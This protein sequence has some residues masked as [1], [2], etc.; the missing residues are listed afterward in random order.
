MNID[1]IDLKILNFLQNDARLSNQELADLVNLS[2]SACHRRVKL[3]ERNGIIEKYQARLNYEKLGI[4]IE[5]IVEIKLIQLTETDHNFFLKQIEDFEEV[6]NAYVITGESNYVLHVATKDLNA[7]SQF[8]INK[9]NKIKGIM[10][11]N[12]KIILDKVIQKKLL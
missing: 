7:F 10:S 4:K 12:S 11:I 3:L 9:L 6:V 5:A 2:P 8:I 1:A